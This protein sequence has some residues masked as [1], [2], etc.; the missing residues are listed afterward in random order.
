MKKELYFM[1]IVKEKIDGELFLEISL[2]PREISFLREKLLVQ[3]EVSWEGQPMS[4]G[5]KMGNDEELFEF[6][7]WEAF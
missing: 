6:E 7:D 1:K 3:K 5:V 2:S 4:V